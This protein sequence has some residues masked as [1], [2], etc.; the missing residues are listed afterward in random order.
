MLFVCS[1]LKTGLHGQLRCLYGSAGVT[2]SFA[3]IFKIL[4][5]CRVLYTVQWAQ[6]G[7]QRP[8]DFAPFVR[9]AVSEGS[10]PRSTSGG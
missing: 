6:F 2:G 1:K 8:V 9:N 10:R 7:M 3:V 4:Q 5:D